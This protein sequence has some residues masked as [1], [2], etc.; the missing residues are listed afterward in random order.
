MYYAP[1]YREILGITQALDI[2]ILI[3]I[4]IMAIGISLYE[5]SQIL[6]A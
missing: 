4:S 3:A 2:F 6:A 5:N 1:A